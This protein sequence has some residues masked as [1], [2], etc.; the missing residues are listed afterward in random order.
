MISVAALR[1]L[2]LTCII[3]LGLPVLLFAA[4]NRIVNSEDVV[5]I[6]APS[7]SGFEEVRKGVFRAVKTQN[8]SHSL[9]TP[10]ALVSNTYY[11]IRYDILELPH[12]K[13]IVT[14]DLYA[15]GYDNPEQETAKV[16]GMNVLGK[17]QDFIFNSGDS[18]PGAHLRLFYSGSPGLEVTNIQ[19][20]RIAAWRIWLKRALQAGTLAALLAL[21]LVAMK[22]VWNSL[23]QIRE[24]EIGA[25]K[26]LASEIAAVAA[27]YFVAVLIRFLMYILMPYWG[28]DEYAYK[29][30]A[31]G[32]WHFGSHGVLTDTMVSF[33]VDYPNLLYSYLISPSFLLG[34]NFYI[35]IK[36]INSILINFA[37]FPSYLI[38]RK[39]LNQSPA[40]VAASLSIAIPFVN[41]GAF[42]VTEVLFFPLFL[43]SIWIAVESV[44]RERYIGWA[45]G[46]GLV[47]AVLMNVRLNA[48]VL[49]PAYFFSILWISLRQKKASSIFA[50]PYW[51]WAF[52][53]FICAYV[54]LKYFLD[55][56]AIGGFGFYGRVAARSEGPLVIILN[57]P[58]GFF[59][60]VIGHLTTLS[61]PYALPIALIIT[62][63][64]TSR[65]KLSI[66]CQFNNF[67]V[68]ASVFSSALFLLTLVF[69]IGVSPFDLGGLGRWHSRY[70]FYIYPLIIIAGLVFADRLKIISSSNHF[71]VI[72]VVI[73]LVACSLYFVK[74][75]GA[76][77]DPWFGSIADNMDVQW[78][79]PAAQ[80]YWIF[81][82]ATAALSWL[83][84]KRYVYFSRALVCFMIVAAA[85]ENYG[86]LQVA[87][88]GPNTHSDICG[89][90]SR[91]FLDQYPGRFVV[92]GDSR[93]NM[94][95]AAFW[96]PYIPEKTFIYNNGS[97]L[98][99]QAELGVSA[100]YLVVNGEIS[101]DTAYRRMLS[102]GKCSIYEM[103]N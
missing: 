10:I 96:N 90:L 34:E 55:G 50:R 88:A 41:L 53:A 25:S 6:G 9:N 31:A 40:L 45:I 92:V 24:S 1:T 35:G 51:L 56:K 7:L 85:V 91:N 83:W 23:C 57:N 33:S 73:L 19:I 67:L 28:G 72:A 60:L 42:A 103:K 2:A 68:I 47:A 17:S 39:Y 37:I 100:N 75:H 62:S 69:S 44:E 32:I 48:M 87:G 20:T 43:L 78:Y 89:S 99:G 76:L 77:Q 102:I 74:I 14:A 3:T 49:L 93:A 18:P 27:L 12:E 36:I 63:I 16:F 80:F 15:P 22:R 8:E 86:T 81:V 38:A 97:K 84:Y 94:I 30:I 29:S 64:M 13:S 59:H 101:V 58:I 71:G 4:P 11:R 26:I 46:F 98:L 65:G 54:G 70:Y 79:R 66:S 52:I 82:A 21:A 5:L 61:I 95:A